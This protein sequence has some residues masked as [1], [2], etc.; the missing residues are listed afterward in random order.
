MPESPQ[1]KNNP[2]PIARPFQE[3]HSEELHEIIRRPPTWPVRWGVTLFFVLMLL[4]LAGSW[5]IRYPDTVT[6]PMTLASGLAPVTVSAPTAEIL[7]DLLVQDGDLVAKGQ[8]LAYTENKSV[9]KDNTTRPAKRNAMI[10]PASGRVLLAAPWQDLRQ[11]SPG[12]KILSIV[13]TNDRVQGIMK[14]SQSSLGKIAV[15]QKVLVKLDAFPYREFGLI[16]G[17]LSHIST[18][19]GQDDLYWGYIDFPQKLKTSQGQE[20]PYRI[21][22]RG[23]AEIITKE[24]RLAERLFLKVSGSK[25]N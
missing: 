11:A 9:L 2:G 20:L 10:A 14:L 19:P 23:Q 22:M 3:L 4:L 24:M 17:M 15:G 1:R 25:N 6:A 16:E 8:M 13:P 7:A 21:G 5:L 18:S 12:Q